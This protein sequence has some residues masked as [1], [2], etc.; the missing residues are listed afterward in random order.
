M[1]EGVLYVTHN[2]SYKRFQEL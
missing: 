2:E 1:K